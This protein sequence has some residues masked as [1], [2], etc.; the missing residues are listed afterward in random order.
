MST[1][2]EQTTNWEQSWKEGRIGF[3][4]SSANPSLVKYA[5][6]LDG[7]TNILV[8]LCG[9]T[10]DMHFLH[11]KGHQIFGVELV[12]Q[13]ITDFFAEWN[14]SPTIDNNSYSH[15]GITLL[16]SNIFA[17]NTSNFPTLHGIFD[18]AALVA[19]PPHIRAQYA[20]LL[21]SLLPAQSKILLITYDMPHPQEE[22]PPF[23]VR[24]H[25]I[26]ALFH[27]ASSVQL[28]EEIHNTA[29]EEP[30]LALRGVEWSKEHIWL[31]EV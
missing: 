22:G 29:A 18:R 12:Q 23:P 6:L 4:L 16:E 28:L 9:K 27:N 5:Q 25:D 26:P 31:I 2:P 7:C 10:L 13:A 1:I 19:L 20:Q 24:Q 3:H 14:V 8:P 11:D 15:E 21:L 30:R 17:I